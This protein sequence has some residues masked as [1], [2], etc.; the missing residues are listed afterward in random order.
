MKRTS[1][2]IYASFI[3]CFC[4]SCADN[5]HD[6]SNFTSSA[7][8]DISDEVPQERHVELSL[9]SKKILSSQSE[10]EQEFDEIQEQIPTLYAET[11]RRYSENWGQHITMVRLQAQEDSIKINRIT[12]NRG[13]CEVLYTI[14]TLPVELS[15]G[16]TV[17]LMPFS[18]PNCSVLSV[19]AFTDRGNINIKL[20][21]K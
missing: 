10:L 11:F 12:V 5:K 6:E 4:T 19:E 1:S 8:R 20:R 2:A 14:P 7:E 9:S 13:A 3:Y 18:F 16:K 15:Y 17:E 21:R